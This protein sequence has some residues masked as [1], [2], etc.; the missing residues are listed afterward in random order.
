MELAKPQHWFVISHALGGAAS[1]IPPGRAEIEDVPHWYW[2]SASASDLASALASGKA[3][4]TGSGRAS[5]KASGRASGSGTGSASA[6]ESDR[7]PVVISSN[8]NSNWKK[9]NSLLHWANTI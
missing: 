7:W 2:A 9:L 4:G 6:F 3:S 1:R 5:G 8:V